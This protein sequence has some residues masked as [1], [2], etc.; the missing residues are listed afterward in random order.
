MEKKS[1]G[2]RKCN[3]AFVAH[4]LNSITIF[5]FRLYWRCW[6]YVH[7]ST[8]PP[9]PPST[10]FL[11]RDPAWALR[12]LLILARVTTGSLR[13]RENHFFINCPSPTPFHVLFTFYF[14]DDQPA[15]FSLPGRS[16]SYT[17]LSLPPI[18]LYIQVN[19]TFCIF[20]W[21]VGCMLCIKIEGISVSAC[22]S[23]TRSSGSVC[24][25]TAHKSQL[26]MTEH[27]STPA[28]KLL[29]SG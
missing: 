29:H 17:L 19:H 9:H 16:C 23:L 1:V 24:F 11:I 20:C 3:F 2:L 10:L 25:V 7:F 28:N 4:S 6:Q 5:N 26:F 21:N 18:F 27:K 14:L 13:A 22:Q 8:I 12:Q 15:L